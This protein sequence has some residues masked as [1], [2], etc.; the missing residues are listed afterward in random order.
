MCHLDFPTIRHSDCELL[1]NKS[2]TRCPKCSTHRK[3]LHALLSRQQKG[4][5]TD[6]TAPDSHVNYRFLTTPEKVDRLQR[7]HSAHRKTKLQLD[8]VKAKLAQAIEEKGVVTDDATHEDLHTIMK[9]NT[10]DV[11]KSFPENSFERL[12]WEQQQKALQLK[13][14]K[15]MRWH[16][17][18]IKWCLYL[19]HLSGK[20]YETLRS[21]GCI[22]L[23]SQRTLR[24]YTHCVRATTG[25]SS[26][27]DEQL[28]QVAGHN[29]CAEWQKYVVLVI[30]EM[31]IKEDYIIKLF[32]LFFLRGKRIM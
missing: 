19:R 17:L 14:A 8:R 31:Y 2:L 21:S 15:S 16:P 7:L 13:N 11:T 5:S 6:K 12:F 9:E 10:V 4:F 25:F 22:Q 29:K 1:I 32:F 30:D 26:A 23:P 20:G 3:L 28:L 18:M 27:V 24:N